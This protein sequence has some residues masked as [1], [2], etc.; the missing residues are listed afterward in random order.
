[1]KKFLF[2]IV[3]L[4][5]FSLK[6][7]EFQH[8]PYVGVGVSALLPQGSAGMRHKLGATAN[9]GVYLAERFAVEV[10]SGAFED[11]ASLALRALCHFGAWEE[12]D[13][14]FGSERIDPFFTFGAA[15][16]F[17]GGQYGPCAGVGTY[18]YLSDYWALR[19]DGMAV[20]GVDRDAA[21]VY[22][23]TAGLQRTF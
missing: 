2:F 15:G 20:L 22:T 9:V 6:A 3:F 19:F 7:M 17:D 18:Y 21:M 10:E 8:A 23:L 13:L 4:C 16:W 1:M 5:A 14:L 12:F 11:K